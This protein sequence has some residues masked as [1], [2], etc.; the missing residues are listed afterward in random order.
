MM[1]NEDDGGQPSTLHGPA[2]PWLTFAI[3]SVVA[4]FAADPP[5]G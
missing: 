1:A 3:L 5:T 2:L 4:R